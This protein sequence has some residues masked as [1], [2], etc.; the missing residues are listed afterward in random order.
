[1]DH[2][3]HTKHLRGFCLNGSFVVKEGGVW[4][5]YFTPC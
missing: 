5:E 1:M 3:Y 4:E 2:F